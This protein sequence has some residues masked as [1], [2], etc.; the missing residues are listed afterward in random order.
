[1]ADE[2]LIVKIILNL[3][4]QEK[5]FIPHRIVL[6]I[7]NLKQL[8]TKQTRNNKKQTKNVMEKKWKSKKELH[9]HFSWL[10]LSWIFKID[11]KNIR[12]CR[13]SI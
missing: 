3:K 4:Q 12:S 6:R 8:A 1:M 5:D 13:Y 7:Y 9:K 10:T 2:N 11:L